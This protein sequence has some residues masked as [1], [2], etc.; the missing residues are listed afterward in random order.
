MVDLPCHCL[1][2]EPKF[3][4]PLSSCLPSGRKDVGSKQGQDEG[5]IG[6]RREQSAVVFNPKKSKNHFEAH[7]YTFASNTVSREVGLFLVS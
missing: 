3:H 6:I 2:E 4:F 7:N 5:V 1:V